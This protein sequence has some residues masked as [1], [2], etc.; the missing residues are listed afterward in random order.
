[1]IGR[2][3][4]ELRFILDMD[5]EL[6]SRCATSARP[7]R[8]ANSRATIARRYSLER[9]RKRVPTSCVSTRSASASSSC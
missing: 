6:A 3:D 1:M 8:V 9:A 7:A 2:D 5:G 4:V